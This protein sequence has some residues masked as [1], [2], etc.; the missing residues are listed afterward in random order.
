MS[1]NNVNDEYANK[2]GSLVRYISATDEKRL[3]HNP[4]NKPI[5]Y[6]VDFV[7][8]LTQNVW[9]I[10][11]DKNFIEMCHF[12]PRRIFIPPPSLKD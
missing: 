3:A 6:T 2:Y 4:D 11:S 8:N 1:R 9:V 12:D 10:Y 7:M 5:S